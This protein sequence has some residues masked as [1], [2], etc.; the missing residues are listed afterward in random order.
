MNT[1][2]RIFINQHNITTGVVR[3]DGEIVLPS[4]GSENNYFWILEDNDGL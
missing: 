4:R 3:R 2:C 1:F